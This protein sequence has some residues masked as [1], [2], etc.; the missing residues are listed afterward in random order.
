VQP[1]NRTL[2][3][4]QILHDFQHGGFSNDFLI[5]SSDPLAMLYNDRSPLENHHVSAGTRLMA[6]PVGHRVVVGVVVGVVG[7]GV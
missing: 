2:P 6:Q 1:L 3:L 4:N 7:V 5:Q